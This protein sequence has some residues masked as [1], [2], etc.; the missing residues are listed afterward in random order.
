MVEINRSNIRIDPMLD[1]NTDWNPP[2]IGAY[3]EIWF[4]A[5]AKFGTHTRNRDDAWVNLYALYSPVYNTVQLEYYVETDTYTL[6]PFPC[7]ATN[8][9]RCI[10][11]NMIEEKCREIE[12]CSCIELLLDEENL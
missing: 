5:D 1:V 10:I 11:M 6:G 8:V 9:E 3:I 2:C 7:E 4:D 12:G